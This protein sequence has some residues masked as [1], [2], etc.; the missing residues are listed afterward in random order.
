MAA[1]IYMMFGDI[2]KRNPTRVLHYT[3]DKTYIEKIEPRIQ[4]ITESPDK[5]KK[6]TYYDS[7]KEPERGWVNIQGPQR[8]VR[9]RYKK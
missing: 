5:G 8:G 3:K 1:S 2:M 9:R 7:E 6:L 4:L